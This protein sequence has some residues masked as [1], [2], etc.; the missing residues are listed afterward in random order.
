MTVLQ[1]TGDTTGT[2]D[3]DSFTPYQFVGTTIEIEASVGSGNASMYWGYSNAHF[4]AL[5][6]NSVVF[7][8]S[9]TS[10]PTVSHTLKALTRDG[11]G[12]EDS[13]SESK[14]LT[15]DQHYVFKIVVAEDSVS[16][17]IDNV[18]FHTAT[19]HIPTDTYAGL[20]HYRSWGSFHTYSATMSADLP[21][22][23][24]TQSFEVGEPAPIDVTFLDTSTGTPISWDWDFGDG[25]EHSTEQNPVHSYA[26]Y[27]NYTVV[28][29][30]TNLF[31]TDDITTVIS[32]NYVILVLK[33]ALAFGNRI[34]D[35]GNVFNEW[36]ISLKYTITDIGDILFGS[37]MSNLTPARLLSIKTYLHNRVR[38]IAA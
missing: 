15:P 7:F 11:S 13:Y 23:S 26:S 34:N 16:Y 35:I 20:N 17:Y 37:G 27:G 4:P 33:T 10:T 12:T 29:T 6:S 5:G 25:S 19:T 8:Y 32:V 14:T 18:L 31:G 36:S 28:L 30:V 24:F 2:Y 22:A 38:R 21:I 3:V 1:S 9:V